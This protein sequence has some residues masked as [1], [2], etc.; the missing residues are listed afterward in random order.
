[1]RQINC[2]FLK[3]QTYFKTFFTYILLRSIWFRPGS[4]PASNALGRART[5]A[6]FCAVWKPR[7]RFWSEN[8]QIT[9]DLTYANPYKS[10]HRDPM[11][12]GENPCS[13]ITFF[14]GTSNQNCTVVFF[15][16]NPSFLP[17]YPQLCLCETALCVDTVIYKTA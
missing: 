14:A 12:G 4:E 5:I 6:S 7:L 2:L 9:E 3:Y 11:A 16:F 13:V 10:Y 17:A 8:I 1:M 15:F